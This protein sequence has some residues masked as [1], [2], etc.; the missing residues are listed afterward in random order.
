MSSRSPKLMM[1]TCS[2]RRAFDG[3]IGVPVYVHALAPSV[4]AAVAPTERLLKR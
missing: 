1:E 3:S 4:T 2:S